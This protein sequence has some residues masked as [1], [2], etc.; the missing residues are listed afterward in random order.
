MATVKKSTLVRAHHIAKE[1][2]KAGSH[3]RNPYA[4]GM[5]QAKK[6]AAKA[7]RGR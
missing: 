1:I 6:A 5:A 3:V 2:V 7:T 4:V